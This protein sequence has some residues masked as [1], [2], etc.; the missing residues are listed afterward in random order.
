MTMTPDEIRK[1]REE[2]IKKQSKKGGGDKWFQVKEG[3]HVVRIGPP[4]KKDGEF[5]KD[6][7]F[8]GRYKNKVYCAKND[9]DEETGK[10]RKCLVCRRVK[11]LRHDK[12][13]RAK[14]LYGL[15]KQNSDALWNVL[16]AK[17]KVKEGKLKVIGTEKKFRIMQLSPSWHNELLDIFGDPEYREN[18]TKGVADLKT[19]RFIRIERIG[20]GRDDTE[21]KFK[22]MKNASPIADSK[23]ERLELKGTLI[24]LDEIV[25]GSS[26]EELKAFLRRMEKKAKTAEEGEEDENGDD[27][28]EES[29]KKKKKHHD[30]DEDEEEDSD[31]DEEEED[32]EEDEDEDESSS[33]KKKKKKSKDEDEDEEEGE[34]D[35][36]DEDEEEEPKKKKKKSKK[37]HDE[38]EEDEDE[39]DEEE[40]EEDDG[41]EDE[42]EKIFKE[43]KKSLK[44]KKKK[45]KHRDEDEDEEED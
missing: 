16:I 40:E 44:D 4:W 7:F 8:H 36:E 35:S 14:K 29:S 28:D 10:R 5:W 2:N 37:H 25:E 6:R 32:E 30:E 1:L 27:D 20:S 13:E 26:D 38:D 21:Y 17:A 18:S 9:V 34:E 22:V 11:E 24:D 31:E 15:I 43:M 45:K 42:K 33:K 3:T 12:S 41:D 23:S 19:G 39:E